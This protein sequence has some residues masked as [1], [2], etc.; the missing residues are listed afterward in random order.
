MELFYSVVLVFLVL[1]TAV[2][3]MAFCEDD[4]V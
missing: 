3:F 1:I 4:S 2:T